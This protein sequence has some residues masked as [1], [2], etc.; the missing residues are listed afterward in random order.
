MQSD[1]P[2]IVAAYFAAEKAKDSRRLSQ[3]FHEDA[4]VRDEGRDHRGVTA[5]M[6]WHRDANKTYRYIVEP[7][8]ASVSGTTVVVRTRVTGNFPGGVAELR[9]TFTLAEDR[10]ISLEMT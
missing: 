1:V 7:L 5:I 10:I 3:C 8:D 9:C 6:A 4:L 2:G